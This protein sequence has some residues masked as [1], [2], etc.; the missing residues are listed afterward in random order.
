MSS[1]SPDLLDD[2]AHEK[3]QEAQQKTKAYY[4]SQYHLISAGFS[5]ILY[6]ASFDVGSRIP[7]VVGSSLIALLER[8]LGD[9]DIG[10]A[11]NVSAWEQ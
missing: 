10:D 4:S 3:S 11:S 6:S 7:K 1:S 9:D 2:E 8:N 5:G